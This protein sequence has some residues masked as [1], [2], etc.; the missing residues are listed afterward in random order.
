MAGQL[1]NLK[2]YFGIKQENEEDYIVNGSSAPLNGSMDPQKRE[3]LSLLT[4][5]SQRLNAVITQAAGEAARTRQKFIEPE[6]LLVGLLYDSVIF[7]LVS[8]MS[9]T[10]PLDIQEAIKNQVV[11]GIATATPQFS[12][13]TKDILELAYTQAKARNEEFILPEHILFA[14]VIN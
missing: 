13:K 5:F 7:K 9:S 6:H 8:Q 12:Q 4:H 11:P 2:R 1:F 14:L 3:S 10:S